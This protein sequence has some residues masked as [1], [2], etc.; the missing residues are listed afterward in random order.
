M[1]KNVELYQELFDLSLV[2]MGDELVSRRGIY[3]HHGIYVGGQKVIHYSGFAKGLFSGAGVVEYI[4][5]NDFCNGEKTWIRRHSNP[6]FKCREIVARAKSRL[7]EDDYSLFSN[8]C[9]HFARWCIFDQAHSEQVELAKNIGVST[10]G[11]VLA[12]G[13]GYGVKKW[14]EGD[15]E[16]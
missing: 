10:L 8:N 14:V 4:S 11:V 12:V 6:P 5:L 3:T 16:I 1:A 2:K 13:L 15:L 7:N 9:E